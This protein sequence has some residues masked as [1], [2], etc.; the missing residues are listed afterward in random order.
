[1]FGCPLAIPF[2]VL[3]KKINEGFSPLVV[4]VGDETGIG[5]SML[6]S[7]LAELVYY[8]A[9]GKIWKPTG[10][11]FFKMSE[12]KGELFKSSKRIFIIEEAEIE[13]G[14]DEWQSI[15]NKYFNRMKSTQR[16]KGNL[17][18]VVIPIFMQL[19]RKHRRSVNF[20][21]DVK[22]RGFFQAYKI[23]KRSA[24]ILGD[25]IGRFHL[26]SCLYNLPN[27]KE[28]YDKLDILNKEK[29]EKE[30][31]EK[32]EMAIELRNAKKDKI[33]YQYTCPYCDFV[34]RSK[35]LPKEFKVC[36]NPECKKYIF[37]DKQHL[38]IIRTFT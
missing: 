21:F 22:Y 25:E 37:W 11:L 16:I 23:I 9:C 35:K 31:G 10:N 26:C 29:I 32:L 33:F 30:E 36:Q 24:Q 12:F 3:A 5:K 34:W 4:I 6:A 17:Y 19:A 7:R 8:R 20:L 18:I 14:S 38:K 1:M 15:Q 13:L 2:E 28:E 27:C